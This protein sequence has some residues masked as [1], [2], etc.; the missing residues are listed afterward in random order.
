M[1][2]G[3]T[4]KDLEVRKG[5]VAL[6]SYEKVEV[7]GVQEVSGTGTGTSSKDHLWMGLQCPT[8]DLMLL[9]VGRRELL[10][11]SQTRS[12]IQPDVAPNG[13][14]GMGWRWKVKS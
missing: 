8:E 4:G 5:V 9:P 2:G 6:Q 3:C 11:I 12:M 7:L 10:K 14:K 13:W 1:G